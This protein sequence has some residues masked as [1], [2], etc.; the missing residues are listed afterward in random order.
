MVNCYIIYGTDE[1]WCG[2]LLRHLWYGRKMV[3]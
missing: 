1:K 3:W 2:E